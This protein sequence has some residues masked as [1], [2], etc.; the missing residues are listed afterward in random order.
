MMSPNAVP[1]ATRHEEAL[2]HEM[3]AQYKMQ[4]DPG[5]T[6]STDIDRLPRFLRCSKDALDERIVGSYERHCRG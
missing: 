5:T 6:V 2:S 3:Y 4:F 1:D